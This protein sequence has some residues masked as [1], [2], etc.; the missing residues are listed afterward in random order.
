MTE[1]LKNAVDTLKKVDFRVSERCDIRPRSFDIAAR[2]DRL[3]LLL[4]F[5]SD[6]DTLSEATAN[7]MKILAKRLL[8]RPLLIGK[9]SRNEK[10]K[11]GVIY[12]RRGISSINVRTL[13]EYFVEGT[14]P[15]VYAS[16]GGLYVDVDGETI[17][18]ARSGRGLSLGDLASEVGVSRRSIKKY[19]DGGMNTTIDKALH[20]EGVLET[21]IVTPLDLLEFQEPE[22]PELDLSHLP[23]RG[24][25]ALRILE[26]LGFTVFPTTQAPFD[27]LSQDKSVTILTGISEYSEAMVRRA[28]LVGN[29]SSV[30]ETQSVF[31]VE[32]AKHD[33]I[34]STVV[35]EKDELKKVGDS[36]ELVDLI[37]CKKS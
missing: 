3:L 9:K 29:I 7:E 13:Y 12:K 4:K 33:S 22:T 28:K 26:N 31:I 24:R 6:V 34:G 10:L 8:G 19:E 18:D 14:P 17:K 5:L 1:I 16:H 36:E 20:L 25:K 15:Y 37:K 23:V 21:E 30:T 35:V 32:N 27:A 11:T 2:R